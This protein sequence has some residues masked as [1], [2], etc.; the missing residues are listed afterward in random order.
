MKYQRKKESATAAKT[1]ALRHCCERNQYTRT[2][3]PP[4]KATTK[5]SP[6]SQSNHF[7]GVSES[8][9]P[10]MCADLSSKEAANSRIAAFSVF[11]KSSALTAGFF[12]NLQRS[13]QNSAR[14]VVVTWPDVPVLL[15]NQSNKVETTGS[16]YEV[17]IFQG[18]FLIVIK[19]NI[20]SNQT[21]DC[22]TQKPMVIL[23]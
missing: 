9:W 11:S 14:P 16:N 22:T 5:S 21:S 17:Q 1:A 13:V 2:T 12:Q 20:K 19:K 3:V 18:L 10:T 6:R 8:I 4:S 7:F 15:L 23:R